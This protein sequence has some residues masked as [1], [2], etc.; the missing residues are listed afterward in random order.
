MNI[1]IIAIKIHIGFI[2]FPSLLLAKDPE[3]FTGIFQK[4]FQQNLTAGNKKR[5]FH[6]S[7]TD[8]DTPLGKQV[9]TSCFI[10]KISKI[11][12]CWISISFLAE[13]QGKPLSVSLYPGMFEECLKPVARLQ[14]TCKNPGRGGY[15]HQKIA[16]ISTIRRLPVWLHL[17]N[18]IW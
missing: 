2:Q 14:N 7:G 9:I 10:K 16:I 17:C 5:T 11:K 12:H 13:V 4:T 1:Y 3:S 8:T 6:L 18:G 15:N